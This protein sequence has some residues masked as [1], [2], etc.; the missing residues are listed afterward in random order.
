M[1]PMAGDG[2]RGTLESRKEAQMPE[3]STTDLLVVA[4]VVVAWF[5][6]FAVLFYL[7]DKLSHFHLHLHHRH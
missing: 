2:A 1:P 7:V 4:L 5:A 6:G 3:I